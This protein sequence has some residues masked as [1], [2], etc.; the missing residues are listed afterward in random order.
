MSSG[1][2]KLHRQ[3]LDWEWYDDINTS[4]LFVHLMLTANHKDNKW[5]GIVIKRGSRLTSLDKLSS[6]TSLSVSK[7]RTAI[8][9]LISTSEITS[10]SHSQHTVFTMINYDMYQ[11]DDKQNDKPATNE[12]QTNNKRIATNKN[13]KNVNNEKNDKKD[14]VAKAPKR[15]TPPTDIE[16]VSY[17]EEKGSTA[18]EAEKF[19]FFYDSK[20][21]MVGKSK[22]KRWQSAASGW[23]KRNK[24]ESKDIMQISNDSDWHLQDQGF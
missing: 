13:D 14:I 24:T 19:W 12:S 15:F 16:T 8:K 4:R 1:W 7:I 2:I 20:N 10:K 5:R 11:D 9:K 3:L 17:F 21:W 18:S 23:I 22:M 6:E